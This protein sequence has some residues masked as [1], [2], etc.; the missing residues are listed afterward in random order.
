MKLIKF[1]ILLL[2]LSL[3]GYFQQN[4]Y[5]PTPLAI[6][7]HQGEPVEEI[8]LME[9]HFHAG[10]AHS[11]DN[12]REIRMGD[13]RFCTV[14]PSPYPTTMTQ[15][16]G[17]QLTVYIKGNS[18]IYY[19]ET[20]DGFTLVKDD[21]DDY[22]KYAED[23]NGDLVPSTFIAHNVGARTSAE[24][25]YV[26]GAEQHLRYTGTKLAQLQAQQ[27]PNQPQ[28]SSG[29]NGPQGV[30]PST[31]NRKALL[32]LI[33]YPDQPFTYATT[34]FDSMTNLVGYNVNGQAGSF[35]DYYY[36]ASNGQLTLS[37]DVYGWY[38]ADSNRAVYGRGSVNGA[39]PL[40]RQAVDA[41][42]AAGVDFSQYDGDGDGRVDA[43][44][45]IHSGR[46][47][48]E[49]GDNGDI[50]SHRSGLGS[51]YKVTY[52]G[53]EI[54]DYIVQPEA[55]WSSYQITNIGVL[56]HEFGHAL[57]L[58]DLYDTNPNNGGS[59]GLGKWDI[60]AGGTWNNGGA[61]PGYFSAW[62]KEQLGWVTPTVLS[63][64]GSISN[65]PSKTA[66]YRINTPDA[67]EY[68]L[69][70]TREQKEWDLYIPGEGLAI[71][72][73]IS[74]GTNGDET[75]KRVDLEAADGLTE[76]DDQVNSGN[77][78]D[79]F[80]FGANNS[81]SDFTSPNML[82][83]NGTATGSSVSNITHSNHLASFNYS[84]GGGIV[85]NCLSQTSYTHFN[86]PT[87][88]GQSFT[89]SGCQSG[90]Y[91][92]SFEVVNY[93]PG[94]DTVNNVTLNIYDGDG[95]GGNLRYTQ[96]GITISTTDNGNWNT[97]TLA[98]GIGTLDYTDGNQYT[99][100]LT[101][102]TDPIR[103][104]FNSSDVI[105]GG[106]R[107]SPSAQVGND[108]AF[109]VNVTNSS[110]LVPTSEIGTESGCVG[111]NLNVPV[112]I[113]NGDNIGAISYKITFD[114]SKL[115]Y[116]QPTNFHAN[117]GSNYTFTNAT[118]A[119][120]SGEITV[121]WWNGTSS[122][123]TS[124]GTSKLFDLE[125]TAKATGTT[126][127]NWVTTAPYGE[128]SDGL[129]N[130][131]N[132]SIFTN[133]SVT[134]N[135]PA[136]AGL[137]SSDAN[138]T[139]CAGESVTFTGTG[140][141]SYD[142]KVNGAS[143]Q[144]G[145]SDTYTT[146]TLNNGDVVTVE[147]TNSDGCTA[148]SAG[149]TTTVN[150]LPQV[151]LTNDATN[152]E[153]CSGD[154]VTFTATGGDVGATYDFA[155]NGTSVQ[156]STSN[157]YSSSTL[158]NGDQVSVTVTNTTGCSASY[159]T[160]GTYVNSA[161]NFD[162]TDDHVNAGNSLGNFGT[163]DFTAEAWIKTTGTP[164]DQ[165]IIS[166]R[167]NCGCENF[168]NILVRSNGTI[169]VELYE[170]S[171]CGNGAVFTSSATVNDGNW[172]HVA[173]T[174]AGNTYTIYVDGVSSYSAT[175]NITNLNNTHDFKIGMYGCSPLP[176]A[177]YFNGDIDEVRLWTVAR[178]AAEITGSMNQELSGSE[179][180]LVAYYN[181]NQT[182]GTALPDLVGSNN[183]TLTNMALS[184]SSSNWVSA[185]NGLTGTGAL[186]TH[187]TITVH[188]DPTASLISNDA[189]N[190]LC[191]GD[192]VTFTASGGTEFEFFVNGSS[193][194]AK[195]ADSTFDATTATLNNGDVITAKVYNANGCSD[196]SSAIT[197]TVSAPISSFTVTGS[198][199]Y[200]PGS[201]PLPITLSG[202][203][204]GVVYRLMLNGTTVV[205][206]LTGTG[207]ALVFNHGIATSTPNIYTV[208]AYHP[209][210]TTCTTPM[211]GIATITLDCYDVTITLN[212]DNG[213]GQGL[214]NTS[215][216][217]FNGMGVSLGTQTTD[218]AGQVTFTNIANGSDYYILAD[219]SSKQYGGIN[220]TD[221]LLINLDFVN[222]QPLVAMKDRAGDVDGNGANNAADA[223]NVA[224]RFV[225]NPYNYV[226]DWLH[227]N[228]TTSKFNVNGA[229]LNLTALVLT[230]GDVN[231][232]YDVS[233]LSNGT[234]THVN[235]FNDGEI[236]A[237]EGATIEIP[238]IANG[239]IEAGAVSMV[240]SY[241]YDV[242]D[243]ENI[244]LG[245]D[246][247]AQNLQ[248]TV[249]DG[250]IRLTWFSLLPLELNNEDILIKI[251]G[252]VHADLTDAYGWTP[253]IT[254]GDETEFANR[255][256]EVIDQINLNVPTIVLPNQSK[257]NRSGAFQQLLYPN[258]ANA[259]TNLEYNLPTEANITIELFDA[260]G[261]QLRVL[262]EGTQTNGIYNLPI[263]TK[264]LESGAYLIKTTVETTDGKK[265]YVEQL[266]IVR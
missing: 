232:S 234:K 243:I 192:A 251:I 16:N 67:N 32:I 56:C 66:S 13:H 259:I 160:T 249:N 197:V 105:T 185:S 91:F 107:Y 212:Y 85:T 256:G 248:Y 44:M 62:C 46:G 208:V 100:Q 47:M 204:A 156:S 226:Q 51:T 266:M 147:V 79:M 131:I 30:F 145:A 97:I 258:P 201:S 213:L 153:I 93:M 17:D 125:F 88:T 170:D 34:A 70:E 124:F 257:L 195:S 262:A 98:G 159:S 82:L 43:V 48:E 65:M 24:I 12:V 19:L 196:S 111:Q 86:S 8:A 119:N 109:K 228:D 110:S 118:T 178:T 96:T 245:D 239:Y 254:L 77:Q 116:V 203:E 155:I 15:P 21:T 129:G 31:G 233:G 130:I 216:E 169:H 127:L 68:F 242:F 164:G 36:D 25:A 71:Y 89:M 141:V 165:P 162:G 22:Y 37:T 252:K 174:R 54:D 189:D 260:V 18:K 95:F 210:T 229:N 144:S 128:L 244:V 117:W 261:R 173:L 4:T 29:Q 50:W 5:T 219:L 230:F 49:T 114:T 92:E 224:N 135:T 167:T 134:I 183:G 101:H 102:P 265:T 81:F 35:R 55:L 187:Q 7:S 28:L 14:Q 41:A 222:I 69:L 121:A 59:A 74:N 115:T 39:R 53:V 60:M 181:F 179:T 247:A 2:A 52:D 99:F 171:G 200:C 94:G 193:V 214:K 61:T 186:I 3:V 231:G 264:A 75:R 237:E 64:S 104:A 158:S 190:I 83:H 253:T 146:A 108:L 80:P 6:T 205:D 149:I 40:I 120:N 202:S 112:N 172:H 76:M 113:T 33:D 126:N 184:G 175:H 235:L 143:V 42:E 132:G 236:V 10:H 122:T 139:I 168:W 194:Q 191:D 241:P 87:N 140:G 142:F 157:T 255:T 63:G 58:P 137:T 227:D 161:L 218:N 250:R 138:N 238:F 11:H 152:N 198:G 221:A 150:A 133:G 103:L 176:F 27:L 123:G 106:N 217:L 163:S 20:S 188:P 225:N 151:T 72:H 182:S 57:G 199:S 73:I 154:Y 211:S 90:G 1:T 78:A 246:L 223:L 23:L 26:K 84:V 180:G 263:D 9:K 177:D 215:V 38:T 220:A 148:T 207:S 45:V 206:S 209:A 136:T 240:I 166:K